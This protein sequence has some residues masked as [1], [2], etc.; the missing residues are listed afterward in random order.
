MKRGQMGEAE[1][2][3]IR[4]KIE[5]KQVLIREQRKVRERLSREC[6][7]TIFHIASTESTIKSMTAEHEASMRGEAEDFM[8]ATA[9]ERREVHQHEEKCAD[10]QR[11]LMSSDVVEREQTVLQA[12]LAALRVDDEKE[13]VANAREMDGLKR[14]L[15]N[16]R[17]DLENV[18]RTTLHDLNVSYQEQAFD[19]MVEEAIVARGELPTL[20]TDL[21]EKT[22]SVNRVMAK[23]CRSFQ[24]AGCAKV[25]RDLADTFVKLQ[26][27]RGEELRESV[28][29]QKEVIVK[30]QEEMKDLGNRLEAF[31]A[32]AGELTKAAAELR[33]VRAESA[34][35][36]E[37]YLHARRWAHT[38]AK[39]VFAFLWTLY[40]ALSPK[41][42]GAQG[43]KDGAEASAASCSHRGH[44]RVFQGQSRRRLGL[45]VLARRGRRWC[46]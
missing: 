36:H 29:S 42:P 3:A 19:A 46:R 37:E 8:Y 33:Q 38:L 44:R 18:F 21:R 17:N 7:D 25:E 10:L 1:K 6:A 45:A 40:I 30:E 14:N 2:H 5:E 39:K 12:R 27:K 13:E 22:R 41:Q 11:I 31:Q 20:R 9:P 15:F 16:V 23:H 32:E 28:R 26:A 43:S 24:G 35:T 4:R 34:R